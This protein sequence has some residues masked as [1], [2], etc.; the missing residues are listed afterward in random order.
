MKQL[1]LVLILSLLI[2]GSTTFALAQGQNKDKNLTYNWN[3]SESQKLSY[4]LELRTDQHNEAGELI[5][6]RKLTGKGYSDISSAND[7][8]MH[9]QQAEGVMANFERKASA[10]IEIIKEAMEVT[11][12]AQTWT[13]KLQVRRMR[14]GSEYEFTIRT[15]LNYGKN[16]PSGLIE[17]ELIKIMW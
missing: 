14:V 13:K 17:L 4:F 7:F 8:A 5:V 15:D 6:E 11:K 16:G 12:I 1:V 2:I 3:S 9:Q 10:V